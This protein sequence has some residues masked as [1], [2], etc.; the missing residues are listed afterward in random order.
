MELLAPNTP[1]FFVE[2]SAVKRA[3]DA[4]QF[5]TTFDYPAQIVSKPGFGKTTALIHLARELDGAYCQIGAAHKSLPNLYRALLSAFDI[6][7]DSQYIRDLHDTLIRTLHRRRDIELEG[8][9]PLLVVDEAQTL[10]ATAFRE[11]LNIQETCGIALVL[12]GNEERL[13]TRNI[14]RGAWAQIESRIGMY[15]S[16]PPLS[17]QDCTAIGA[18]YGVEGM[19]AYS[20]IK[21]FGMRTNVRDLVRL[22]RQATALTAGTNGVNLNHIETAIVGLHGRN[23][24]LSLLKPRAA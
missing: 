12:S 23:E 19:P 5:A 8:G 10:E 13:A 1:E 24:A 18:A 17:E 15:V 11:L 4:I 2:I 14:E 16:L 6:M 9:K 7:H 22:L 3:R 21:N 20:A